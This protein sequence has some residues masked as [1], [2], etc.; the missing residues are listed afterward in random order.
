[1]FD[2]NLDY[3]LTVEHNY[4]YEN[5]TVYFRMMEDIE[6]ARPRVGDFEG[7]SNNTTHWIHVGSSLRQ[8]ESAWPKG[9]EKSLRSLQ[10][11]GDEKCFLAFSVKC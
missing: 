6:S 9:C 4:V 11:N 7:R 10:Q 5:V 3:N 2:M 8:N 1:M